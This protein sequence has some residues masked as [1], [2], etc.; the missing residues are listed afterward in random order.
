MG[1]L[2]FKNKRAQVT[3]FIILG[4]VI[5]FVMA[6]SM[7]AKENIKKKELVEVAQNQV[8]SYFESTNIKTYIEIF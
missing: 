6:L 4:I 8:Y 7:S 2:V 1:H 5:L 3:F